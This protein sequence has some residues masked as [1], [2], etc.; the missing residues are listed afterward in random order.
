MPPP[1]AGEVYDEQGRR[2][3]H[4]AF[5]GGFSAGYF[6]SVGSAEGWAPST[7]SSSRSRRAD[8]V[9]Q[10]PQ[11]FMDADDGLLGQELQVQA[12]FN[13]LGSTS[14][15]IA[16]R[17]AEASATGA[18]GAGAAIPGPAPSELIVPADDS[19]GRKLLRAMGWREGTRVGPTAEECDEIRHASG[20]AAE[21]LLASVAHRSLS[22]LDQFPDPKADAH[23]VG[24][25]QEARE[26]GAAG[27]E[28]GRGAAAS[29]YSMDD[30][31]KRP[32]AGTRRGAAGASMPLDTLRGTCG[33]AL[34]DGDDDVYDR[35]PAYADKLAGAIVWCRRSL[36]RG[37]LVCAH[38]RVTR[39]GET[40]DL[41]SGASDDESH[42]VLPAGNVS[43]R[44]A[45]PGHGGRVTGF[46]A[47]VEPDFE[48]PVWR[49]PSPPS[50]FRA[51]H[52]FDTPGPASAA[53][54]G[55]SADVRAQGLLRHADSFLRPAK[56]MSRHRSTGRF[57]GRAEVDARRRASG[58]SRDV[59]NGG[60]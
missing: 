13:A 14:D 56:T 40:A 42:V 21:R 7:F 46:V 5:T 53:R 23:G 24:F 2:R 18:G 3:F 59:Y 31:T 15:E 35:N 16:H 9:A 50:T 38:A 8:H 36:G 41:G 22:T 27:R 11:D 51:W 33:F 58:S 57:D 47:A 37:V 20:V 52:V 10:R 49:A 26:F 34:D 17:H 4:G 25:V 29:V 6:N 48:R 30:V 28:R 55:A 54:A 19:I 1:K 45:I 12:R 32:E 39:L 44:A 60:S 43:I